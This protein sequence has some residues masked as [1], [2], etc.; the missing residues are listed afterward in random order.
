MSNTPIN[1]LCDLISAV[2]GM[3]PPSRSAPVD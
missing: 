1:T 2:K 3:I